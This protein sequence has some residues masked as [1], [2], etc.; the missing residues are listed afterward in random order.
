MLL[1]KGERPARSIATAGTK[2]VLKALTWWA[3]QLRR[4]ELTHYRLGR[5]GLYN[6]V[7][8]DMTL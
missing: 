3:T 6:C 8:H 7:A 1:A 5:I 4:G 2:I